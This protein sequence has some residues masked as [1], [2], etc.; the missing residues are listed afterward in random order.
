[1]SNSQADERC[2]S[3][4][5]FLGCLSV[6]VRLFRPEHHQNRQ[7]DTL[8]A[9][10]AA[11]NINL[12]RDR[13]LSWESRASGA[14]RNINDGLWSWNPGA[15]HSLTRDLTTRHRHLL[16]Q[17]QTR[18]LDITGPGVAKQNCNTE[19]RNNQALESDAMLEM[20]TGTQISPPVR[21]SVCRTSEVVTP[22]SVQAPQ[23]ECSRIVISRSEALLDKTSAIRTIHPDRQSRPS[24]RARHDSD[25]PDEQ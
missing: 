21:G 6:R 8:D 23:C 22:P 4:R 11:R 2:Q 25:Q 5:L 15:S 24:N 9:D 10:V 16:P 13:P 19:E 7:G 17:S 12:R 20:S 18:G 1:M 3:Q 14:R